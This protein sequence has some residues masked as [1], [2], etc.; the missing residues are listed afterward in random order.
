[1]RIS[2]RESYC[3]PFNCLRSLFCCYL[4]SLVRTKDAPNLAPI[5]DSAANPIPISDSAAVSASVDDESGEGKAGA[6]SVEEVRKSCLKKLDGEKKGNVK[7]KDLLGKELVEIKEYE[8]SDSE[9]QD[10]DD[11]NSACICSIQ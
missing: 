11:G 9:S 10:D 4:P 2:F 8:P 1:M 5:S 3:A 7:W 6:L